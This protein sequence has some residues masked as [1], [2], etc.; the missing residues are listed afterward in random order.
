MSTRR[1]FLLQTALGFGALAVPGLSATAGTIIK[2]GE[3][4]AGPLLPVGM[5]GYTFAKFNIDQ[6]IEMLNRINVRN[7]SL[8]DIHLPIN[9]TP[10]QIREVT[11][12]IANAG[13]KIY[14]VGVIY[15]K[16]QTEVD[17]AFA[18]AKRVG[19]P[20]IV[21]VPTPEL[22]DYTEQKVKE[23]NIKIAIHN[24]G[25]ED[26]LYPG[27]KSVY[28]LI[29]N[30]DARMGICLDIG[31]AMRAGEEPAQ[32]VL[33]YRTRLFDLHIKDVTAAAKDGKATEIGRGVIDFGKLTTNLLKIRYPGIC[34]I[35][36][37]K[38]M[39]DPLVGIAESVGYFRGVSRKGA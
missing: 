5:A 25:P 7:L 33:N 8:K 12:K 38:D 21:G 13:I 32:A 16:T 30:R 3:T 4:E 28:D 14:A 29:R 22:L 26:K 31:H 23:Y 36:Y 17:N 18:Y 35:E 19:V 10:G 34:A 27:P 20:L 9:S 39:N 2:K 15:M 37:E 6:A 24:H 1:N 11:E